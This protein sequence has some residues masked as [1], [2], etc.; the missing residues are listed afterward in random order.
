MPVSTNIS[1]FGRQVILL[2]NIIIIPVYLLQQ[3]IIYCAGI[4]LLAT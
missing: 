4:I 1:N 2:I 3:S